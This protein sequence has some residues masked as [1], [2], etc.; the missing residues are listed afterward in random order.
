MD[1][2]KRCEDKYPYN[3]AVTS[4]TFMKRRLGNPT[5]VLVLNNMPKRAFFEPSIYDTV[6]AFSTIVI[7][8]III[9]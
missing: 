9:N 3:A 4:E 8:T 2:K 1:Y 6:K 7:I 5:L